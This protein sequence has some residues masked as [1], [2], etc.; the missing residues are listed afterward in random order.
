MLATFKEGIRQGSLTITEE[1]RKVISLGN[2]SSGSGLAS[3]LAADIQVKKTAFWFR[4]FLRYD[5]GCV[6]L[7]F[8]P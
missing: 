2:T 7:I 1:D 8:F 6:W 5:L 4:I 3:G